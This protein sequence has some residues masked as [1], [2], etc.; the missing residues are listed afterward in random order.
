MNVI[1][2]KYGQHYIA[3]VQLS[4]S[5]YFICVLHTNLLSTLN[6]QDDATKLLLVTTQVPRPPKE[7][8]FLIFMH[9]FIAA[10]Y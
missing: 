7:V 3:F 9:T 5:P 10:V 6:S 2:L 8:F 1:I 4:W